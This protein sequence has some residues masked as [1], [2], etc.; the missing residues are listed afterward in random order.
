[1]P[2]RQALHTRY[3]G[4]IRKLLPS[5]IQTKSYLR[6]AWSIMTHERATMHA[7]WSTI[8]KPSK[9]TGLYG[10]WR[11]AS[12]LKKWT[13]CHPIPHAG[14]DYI[15]LHKRTRLPLHQSTIGSSTALLRDPYKQMN[16]GVRS[17]FKSMWWMIQRWKANPSFTWKIQPWSTACINRVPCVRH[18]WLL[19]IF[20]TLVRF[21][22]HGNIQYLLF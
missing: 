10:S 9:V 22:V 20:I 15:F 11:K 14:Q 8:L 13:S 3:V 1:M 17:T 2:H 19:I 4:P 5:P 21:L 7:S 6:L 18:H 12:N 16:D